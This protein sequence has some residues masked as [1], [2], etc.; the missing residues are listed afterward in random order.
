MAVAP[1]VSVIIPAY[2]ADAT[3]ASVLAALRPQGMACGLPGIVSATPG[4]AA[5]R[6]EG[7]LLAANRVPAWIEALRT[8]DALGAAGRREAGRGWRLMAIARVRMRN[9]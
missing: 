9:G 6:P 2:H 7:V 5:R 3:L 8:V 1:R 4:L